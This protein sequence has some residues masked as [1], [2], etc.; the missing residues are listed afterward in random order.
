MAK[1][2]KKNNNSR[3]DIN[4]KGIKTHWVQ[5][6]H[7]Y[8]SNFRLPSDSD[9]I[10]ESIKLYAARIY[11]DLTTQGYTINGT[12]DIVNGEGQIVGIGDVPVDDF[13]GGITTR[14]EMSILDIAFNDDWDLTSYNQLYNKIDPDRAKGKVQTLRTENGTVADVQRYILTVDSDGVSQY[15][16]GETFIRLR[17][18]K[19][20]ETD[21]FARKIVTD[22]VLN[23][24]KNDNSTDVE[25]KSDLTVKQKSTLG[26]I[27]IEN[28]SISTDSEVRTAPYGIDIERSTRFGENVGIDGNL[29]VIGNS[30]FDGY[31]TFGKEGKPYETHTFYG[32]T[33]INGDSD[34]ETIL[35]VTGGNT[36]LDG[37]LLVN[38]FTKIDDDFEVTGNTKFGG[39]LRADGEMEVGDT[40]T[41]G[42]QVEEPHTF[43]VG[44]SEYS[45]GQYSGE[46][47]IHSNVPVIF[48]EELTVRGDF[49]H[50]SEKFETNADLIFINANQGELGSV[51]LSGA[52]LKIGVDSGDPLNPDPNL[53]AYLY[54]S[55]TAL[56]DDSDADTSN[57]YFI[58]QD[59]VA[60]LESAAT[61][62]YPSAS[63]MYDV[64]M[65]NLN[66]EKGLFRDDV[67]VRGRLT[68]NGGT[69]F[70]TE[71]NLSIS[72]NFIQ[73]NDGESGPGVFSGMGYAGIEVDRGLDSDGAG[74]IRLGRNYDNVGIVWSDRDTDWRLIR[75]TS[76]EVN[77]PDT[78][79]GGN[80]PSTANGDF[81]DLKVDRLKFEESHGG[82]LVEGH[83]LDIGSR[84]VDLSFIKPL[85]IKN[86]NNDA[87]LAGYLWSTSSDKGTN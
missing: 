82:I 80:G 77:S 39:Q 53:G 52:G 15:I 74:S 51:G 66:A 3:F 7:T 70:R 59:G 71:E 33:S 43:R 34:G 17:L 63:N 29:K 62:T 55:P 50:E 2:I 10:V 87:V 61:P 76:E 1:N 60:Q 40:L 32:I 38:Q 41:V 30:A 8:D 86:K 83:D 84:D 79:N 49:K 54:F 69:V 18:G 4:S 25:I 75:G 44:P 5:S 11:E 28:N 72:N 21:F 6:N 24:L 47:S 58:N 19:V 27:T 37:E 20:L 22:Q 14:G 56:M 42:D 64:Y 45:D 85:T 57:F 67:V 73:L 31:N 46:Y 65:R 16:H 26:R 81:V 12:G 13:D 35:Q 23:V 48:E 36:V 68:V 9:A 78:M